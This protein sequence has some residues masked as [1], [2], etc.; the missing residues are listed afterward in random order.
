MFSIGQENLQVLKI[1]DSNF[2]SVVIKMAFKTPGYLTNSQ[3]ELKL[4]HH[5]FVWP[6]GYPWP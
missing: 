5:G 6:T 2:E 1:I 4:S 3:I